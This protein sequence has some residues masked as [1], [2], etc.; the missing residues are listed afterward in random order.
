MRCSEFGAAGAGWRD[1]EYG[2]SRGEEQQA[3]GSGHGCG[4]GA[5]G[6]YPGGFYGIYPLPLS[7]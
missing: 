6:R 3:W 4:V 5:A 1:G 7:R 2:V